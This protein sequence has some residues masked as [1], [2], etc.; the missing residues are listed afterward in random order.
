MRKLFGAESMSSWL[1]QVFSF[2]LST[3]R[4]L[5][6]DDLF[7]PSGRVRLSTR[8][9]E[10]ERVRE[11]EREIGERE[12]RERQTERKESEMEKESEREGDRER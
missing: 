4:L 5:S 7:C 2:S 6:E 8:P 11:R 1:C 3:Q 9:W 12:G 10:R